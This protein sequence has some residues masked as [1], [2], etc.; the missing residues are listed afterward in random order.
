M[1]ETK[2]GKP[3]HEGWLLA[4]LAAIQFTAV[5]D[6]MIVMPL[7]PR[8]IETFHIT[9]EQF[10]VIIASYAVAAGISGLAA[11]FFIDR[12]DRKKALLTLYSG[13]TL[14]TLFCAIA[15]TYLGLVAARAMAGAF[16]GITMGMIMA[17]VGDVIPE[18][19]RGKAMGIVMSS[20]SVASIFG[21]PIGL[22]LAE[23]MDNWHIPFFALAGLC[24]L[25]LPFIHVAMPPLR[26]HIDRI[27]RQPPAKMIT[28]I[29]SE[30]KNLRALGFMAMLMCAGFTIFP[31]LATYLVH[32]VGLT[33]SQLPLIY[34]CGGICTLV[35]M[36]VIGR[37]ADRAGKKRVFTIMMVAS[38]VP[39]L[40]VT[41]LPHVALSLALVVSTVFMVCSS[42]RTVPAMALLTAS[43]EPHH[44][45]G[46]MSINSS[47]QQISMGL[48]AWLSGK[49]IQ[50]TG[51]HMSRF[52]VAGIVS[53]FFGC[54]AIYL[55]RYLRVIGGAPSQPALVET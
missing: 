41:N 34:I 8:Y 54:A 12:F 38:M 55:V 17:V 47:V 42:G 31:Y 15:P 44:R 26:G 4:V 52:G 22:Y 1:S 40:I 13:F 14:G 39:V 37:W 21:V 48:A 24:A 46:F 30:P 7:G 19:R 23:S 16:G 9:T 28:A 29:L 27:A 51:E 35:S 6:F 2:P 11:A 10:G 18:A 33:R 45:G 5:V 25:V 3:I 36:N 32:N 20:F 43:V 50:D 49:I 53:V